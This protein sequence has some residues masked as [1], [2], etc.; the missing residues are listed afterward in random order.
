MTINLSLVHAL[1]L[2]LHVAPVG[3]KHVKAHVCLHL[4][5][6]LHLSGGPPTCGA[7]TAHTQISSPAATGLRTGVQVF[8]G[9][10]QVTSAV[11]TT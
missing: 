5:V 1:W 10:V 4:Q 9:I 7:L 6:F 3:D 11:V 2:E 8:R